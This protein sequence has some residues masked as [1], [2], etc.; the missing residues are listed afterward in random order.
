LSAESESFRSDIGI[1]DGILSQRSSNFKAVK[2]SGNRFQGLARQYSNFGSEI[3]I[4]KKEKVEDI[5]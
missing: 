4:Y 2:F 5:D 1:F 3:G